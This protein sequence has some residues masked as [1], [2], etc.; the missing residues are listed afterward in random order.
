MPTDNQ[1]PGVRWRVDFI[2]CSTDD[3]HAV[4]S[5]WDEADALRESYLFRKGGHDRTAIITEDTVHGSD[6]NGWSTGATPCPLDNGERG[7][8]DG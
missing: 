1:V 3:G 6:C 5:T 7:G 8:S 2:C 4:R